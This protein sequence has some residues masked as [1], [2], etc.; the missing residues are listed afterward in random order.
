MTKT[1]LLAFFGGEFTKS[2]ACYLIKKDALSFWLPTPRFPGY[3]PGQGVRSNFQDR[4]KTL[5]VSAKCTL[6]V[7]PARQLCSVRAR[8]RT[9]VLC[10][11]TE[12]RLNSSRHKQQR[13]EEGRSHAAVF[14]HTFF[15]S[16]L[17][18]PLKT[19]DAAAALTAV[20]VT[21]MTSSG[22]PSVL[23][24]SELSGLCRYPLRPPSSPS[25]PSFPPPTQQGCCCCCA[26]VSPLAHVEVSQSTSASCAACLALSTGWEKQAC[27]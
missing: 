25:R 8:T 24:Y 22:F 23:C 5:L 2:L 13:Q 3:A 27:V 20:G 17:D 4:H 1:L 9:P 12:P 21:V 14:P 19:L 26:H 10:A 16:P 15:R 11:H 18:F 6:D 7:S